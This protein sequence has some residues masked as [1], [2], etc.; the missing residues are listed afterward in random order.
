M[1]S[2]RITIE[3]FNLLQVSLN[4]SLGELSR[5]LDHEF[6]ALVVHTQHLCKYEEYCL[7]FSLVP[8]GLLIT[9]TL[10]TT[11]ETQCK[12]AVSNPLFSSH[13]YFEKN[14]INLP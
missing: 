11:K 14:E 8:P 10:V 7:F 6:F 3:L 13:K 9:V 2:S 4:T 1:F 5:I 12:G